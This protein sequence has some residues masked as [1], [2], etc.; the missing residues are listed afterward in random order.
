MMDD[1]AADR[2]TATYGDNFTRLTETKT[3][4]DPTNLFKVNYNIPPSTKGPA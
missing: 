1:E 2:L 3:R 4:Y